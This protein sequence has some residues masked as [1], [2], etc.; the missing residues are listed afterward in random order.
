MNVATLWKENGKFNQAI[1]LLNDGISRFPE[2]IDMLSLLPHCYLLTDRI[3]LA[4]RYLDKATKIAPDNASVG[5]TTARLKVKEQKP[6]EGL[7]VA[8][9]TGQKFPDDIEAMGVL[10]ACL[11]ANGEAGESL[12]IL[13]KV[14]ELNPNYAEALINRGLIRLSQ[15]KRT[16]AL[17]DLELAYRLKPHIKQICNVV[18]G[19]KMDAQDYSDAIALLI[20]MIEINSTNEILLGNLA[21]CHHHINK[22][23]TAI[24]I[25]QKT[26]DIKYNYTEAHLDLGDALTSQVRL[27]EAC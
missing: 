22:V 12:H 2:N 23:E 11:R 3:E 13:N 5:W 21:L 14:I 10:G 9:D 18:V 16:E 19:L 15:E 7:N 20:D 26:I 27:K 4:T 25:Y 1:D 8:R 17:S 6:L 24:G